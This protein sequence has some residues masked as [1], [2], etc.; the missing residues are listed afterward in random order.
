MKGWVRWALLISAS[1]ALLVLAAV[2][3]IVLRPAYTPAIAG[4]NSVAELDRLKIGGVYQY[5]LI[6]GDD[7][8]NPVL[9][10]LHGGPGMPMMY[11]AYRFQRPLEAKFIV[12]QWDRRGAGKSYDPRIATS[13]M[14]LKQEMSD[15]RELVNY[16]R[17]RFHKRRIYLVGHSYGTLLGVLVVQHYPQLFLA[18]V[19]IGQLACSQAQ[20]AAYQNAWIRW[21]ADDL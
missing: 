17:A 16:L 19:G 13:S 5:V 21:H 1:M 12:V 4:P 10:F 7:T 9:L 20:N 18:Y 15:T 6:R 8:A 2:G 3:Y 11:L 14:S